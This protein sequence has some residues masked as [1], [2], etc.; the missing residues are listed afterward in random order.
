MVE[1]LGCRKRVLSKSKKP[2]FQSFMQGFGNLCVQTP[3]A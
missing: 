2:V 1:K 3:L